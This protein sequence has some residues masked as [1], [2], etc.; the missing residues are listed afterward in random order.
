MIH[1]HL[2]FFR[3]SFFFLSFFLFV[4]SLCFVVVGFVVVVVA[5]RFG[6]N[7]VLFLD[8]SRSLYCLLRM[9][10]ICV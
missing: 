1:V 3:P 10:N 4:V 9:S 2:S 5:V 8:K 7:Y 6:L